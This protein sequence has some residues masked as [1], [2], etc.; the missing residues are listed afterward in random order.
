MHVKIEFDTE[1]YDGRRIKIYHD[2]KKIHDLE[3]IHLVLMSGFKP[4]YTINFHNEILEIVEL[5]Y[6]ELLKKKVAEAL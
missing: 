1:D 2:G 3:N 5:G 6:K 4:I